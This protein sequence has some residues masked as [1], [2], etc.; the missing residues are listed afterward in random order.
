MGS[1]SL[2]NK[3]GHAFILLEGF[4]QGEMVPTNQVVIHNGNEAILL[5]PGGH[6]VHYEVIN[7]VSALI[8]ISDLK[9]LFFSHQDPDIIAAAN[10]WLML[11]EADAYISKLWVRFIPHFG[12]DELMIPRLRGIPDEG[13]RLKLGNTELII[14]PAHFLHSAGNFQVYDP[15]S[16]TLFSGDLGASIGPDYVEVTDFDAHIQYMEGFHLRYMPSN[17]ANKCWAEMVR[18]LEIE[19]IVPQHGAIFP[20]AATSRRFIDWIAQL[21]GAVEILKDSYRIPGASQP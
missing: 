3:D 12:I 8:P 9:Y 10:A 16:K 4:G 19:R 17:Q 2:Y 21:P 7:E 5:D 13:M 18:G 6:K 20:D 14:L 15:V 1:T 11:T